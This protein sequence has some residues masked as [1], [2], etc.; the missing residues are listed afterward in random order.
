MIQLLVT[1]ELVLNMNDALNL[2]PVKATL[3][4]DHLSEAI[5]GAAHKLSITELKPK[6]REAIISY[7]TGNDTFVVLP[8]GY[9]KSLIYAILPLVFNKI[10][11]TIKCLLLLNCVF[12]FFIINILL[13]RH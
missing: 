7:V 2:S 11:G 6:Q 9:G 1:P 5:S 13:L 8:T 10:R 4:I 3:T 12:I